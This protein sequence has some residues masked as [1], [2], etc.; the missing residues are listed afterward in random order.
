MVE[1]AAGWAEGEE[2]C[3]ADG[4]AE[5]MAGEGRERRAGDEEG[6]EVFGSH[7]SGGKLPG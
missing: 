1:G 7:R 5:R 4:G 2:G 6:E 3:G